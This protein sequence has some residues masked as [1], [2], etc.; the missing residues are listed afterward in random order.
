MRRLLGDFWPGLAEE[1][2]MPLRRLADVAAVLAE[3]EGDPARGGEK[4]RTLVQTPPRPLD[5][6]PTRLRGS[7]RGDAHARNQLEGEAE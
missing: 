1:R 7:V 3:L 6:P 2:A 4:V 5:T